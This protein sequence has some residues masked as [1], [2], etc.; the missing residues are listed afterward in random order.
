MALP[1]S[2]K[3]LAVGFAASGIVHLV[4]PEFYVPLMPSWVPAHREVIL[5]SGVA[6]LACAA[7]LA[8]PA[9]RRAAGWASALL[10]A[11][12][13]P[14][15]HQDGRRPR[16]RTTPAQG[17]VVRPA[18]DA[19]PDDQGRSARRARLTVP[20]HRTAQ[21]ASVLRRGPQVGRT[22]AVGHD[23]P[24]GRRP[25]GSVGVEE[26]RGVRS[27]SA[28]HRTT[29]R[30]SWRARRRAGCAARSPGWGR[31]VGEDVDGRRSGGRRGRRPPPAPSRSAGAVSGGWRGR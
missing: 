4:K 12:R 8:V 18:P 17:R 1:R 14:G 13:L 5:G 22:L 9:T 26:Q 25:G 19:A 16:R 10:L 11:R 2:T 21:A 6:E 24:H 30:C 20:L 31:A 3:F 29:S 23:A 7:G 28:D 27:P 15:Q